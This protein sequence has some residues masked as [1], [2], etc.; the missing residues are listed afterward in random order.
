MDLT[1]RLD[2]RVYLFE[3]KVVESAPKD[4]PARPPAAM[5]AVARAGLRGQ[6]PAAGGPVHLIGVEFSKQTRNVSAFEAAAARARTP[7]A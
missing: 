4:A 6:V 2:G 7:D 3:F 5:D 1:V